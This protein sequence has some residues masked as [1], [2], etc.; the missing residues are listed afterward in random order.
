METAL[1]AAL[2]ALPNEQSVMVS[3]I[4]ALLVGYDI[5]WQND[6]IQPVE[7]EQVKTAPI[8]NLATNQPSRTFKIAMKLDVLGVRDGQVGIMDHKTTSEDIEDPAAPYWRQLVIEGQ[9]S[10]YWLGMWLNGV[11]VDF[12]QWDVVRKPGIAPRQITKAEMKDLLHTKQWFGYDIPEGEIAT[13]AE[14]GRE[15]LALYEAR[16]LQDCVTERPQRYFQRRTIPRL[17]DDIAEYASELWD[18]GQELVQIRRSGRHIRNSGACMEYNRPCRFLAVCSGHDDIESTNWRKREFVHPELEGLDGDGR[19]LVTN[20][21]IR[22]FQTCR[23]KHFYA[24][25]LGVEKVTEEDVESLM[26]G[27]LWHTALEAYFN[28]KKGQHHV[29]TTDSLSAG[30]CGTGCDL[31]QVHA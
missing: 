26:F 11:K 10:H 15:T 19:D 24:Y 4:R 29:N 28:H 1:Q 9:L 6:T 5:R 16:L 22:T 17:D 20:S 8:I 13:A 23:R 14:T 2:D 7:V 21:R 30:E 18:L 25:E 31:A 27:N 3:K 12:G